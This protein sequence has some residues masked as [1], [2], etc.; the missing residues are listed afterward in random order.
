MTLMSIIVWLMFGGIAG[1]IASLIAGTNYRQGIAENIVVG[2][3]G[4]LTGGFIVSWLGGRGISAGFDPYSLLVAVVGATALLLGY[5]AV[6]R[7][8]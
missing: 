7:S 6:S 2:C 3:I 4:A 1:W 5:R 8:M